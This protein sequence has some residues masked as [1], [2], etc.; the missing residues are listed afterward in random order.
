[1][2]SGGHQDALIAQFNVHSTPS[3]SINYFGVWVRA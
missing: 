2:R 3:F 1:L